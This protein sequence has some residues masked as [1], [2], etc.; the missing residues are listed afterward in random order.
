M[1]PVLVLSSLVGMGLAL[2]PPPAQITA[3]PIELAR[4]VTA[5]PAPAISFTTTCWCETIP[6]LTR[7]RRVFRLSFPSLPFAALSFASPPLFSPS[8]HTH[9]QSAWP[10]LPPSTGRRGEKADTDGDMGRRDTSIRLW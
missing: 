7:V 5:A 6:F 8:F 10:L 9:A 3:A 4:A 1:L 2:A